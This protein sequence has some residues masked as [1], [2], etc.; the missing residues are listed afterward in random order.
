[1][2]ASPDMDKEQQG[3]KPGA[4]RVPCRVLETIQKQQSGPGVAGSK[5]CFNSV[6][7]NEQGMY[8]PREQR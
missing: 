6:N 4:I 8:K 7:R 1:M 3:V 2:Q 5:W